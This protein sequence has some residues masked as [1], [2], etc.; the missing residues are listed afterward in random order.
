MFLNLKCYIAIKD[1]DSRPS[2]ISDIEQ[3]DLSYNLNHLHSICLTK[4]ELA[5]YSVSFSVGKEELYIL[6]P[7]K[8]E[9]IEFKNQ[10]QKIIREGGEDLV[11][12]FS[13]K[14]NIIAQIKDDTFLNKK[15]WWEDPIFIEKFN[16]L[17]ETKCI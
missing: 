5:E 1:N 4:S 14:Q 17:G 12:D 2:E 6:F 7:D 10:I 9:A 3:A 13:E 16:S 8:N 15:I 11:I